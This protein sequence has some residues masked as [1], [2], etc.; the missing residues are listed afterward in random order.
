MNPHKVWPGDI[1]GE[2][3]LFGEKAWDAGG[4]MFLKRRGS[5]KLEALE[6]QAVCPC[7]E[8]ILKWNSNK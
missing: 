2:R 6:L 4:S 8:I 1:K 7:G 5:G 3:Q